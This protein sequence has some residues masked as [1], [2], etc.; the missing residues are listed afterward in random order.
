MVFSDGAECPG[1]GAR[2]TRVLFA[3]RRGG[4]S[5]GSAGSAARGGLELLGPVRE[6]QPCRYVMHVASDRACGDD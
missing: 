4:A 6:R 1:F 5:A 2:E 3:C